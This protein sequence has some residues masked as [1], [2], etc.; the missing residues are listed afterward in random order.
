MEDAR[1][2]SDEDHSAA[3]RRRRF[4]DGFRSLVAPFQFAAWQ[5]NCDQSGFARA[6][7]ARARNNGG[8]G[9]DD[10][11]G[12]VSPEQFQLGRKLGRRD[13]GVVVIATKLRPCVGGLSVGSG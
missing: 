9:F 6:Y 2:V 3:D 13:T 5:I 8:G 4:A 10:V 11:A 7:V 1:Q 12:V